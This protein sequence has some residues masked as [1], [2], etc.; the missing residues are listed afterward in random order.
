MAAHIAEER[1]ARCGGVEAA[2]YALGG[3]AG[4]LEVQG[5]VGEGG[6]PLLDAELS[7]VAVVAGDDLGEPL[8]QTVDVAHA[9]T[10]R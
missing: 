6:G 3:A 10:A 9:D 4:V 2:A 5:L 1:N 8:L 7:A